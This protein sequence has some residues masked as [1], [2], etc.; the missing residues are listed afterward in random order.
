M[1]FSENCNPELRK[2]LMENPG[3]Y[4]QII[5][6]YLEKKHSLLH[7]SSSVIKDNTVTVTGISKGR[8]HTF[9]SNQ[10][11]N[12]VDICF[13]DGKLLSFRKGQGHK[14]AYEAALSLQIGDRVEITDTH[15]GRFIGPRVDY[16]YSIY[17]DG[18]LFLRHHQTK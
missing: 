5:A 12:Y 2:A 15:K 14:G 17:K 3:N 10:Y 4:K 11:Y 8:R 7:N 9:V 6:D 13:S 1:T 16:E 18:K